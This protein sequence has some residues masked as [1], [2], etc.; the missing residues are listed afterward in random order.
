MKTR[1]DTHNGLAVPICAALAVLVT[2]ASVRAGKLGSFER[3][4]GGR[5]PPPRS[6][7]SSDDSSSSLGSFEDDSPPPRRRPRRRPPPP[8]YFHHEDPYYY[9]GCWYCRYHHPCLFH[10]HRHP[11]YDTDL[12]AVPPVGTRTNEVEEFVYE[13]IAGDPI[14]PTARFDFGWQAVE[15]DVQAFDSALEIGYGPIA[16]RGRI[17]HYREDDPDD[18]LDLSSILG[19]WRIPVSQEMELDVGIGGA[20]LEGD[21]R[22]SG[23]NISLALRAWVPN[24]YIG[25]EYRGEFIDIGDGLNSNDF[26]VL[27]HVKWVA[28]RAG[29]RW[30]HTTHDSLDGPF[31][32][33]SLTF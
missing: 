1:H 22:Q 5:P 16:A 4:T 20:V 32:G 18:T 19:L 7:S 14:L 24:R 33:A 6:S 9:H 23:V 28:L 8:G 25:F 27:L 12:S 29:Y 21:E 15:S 26:S 31:A 3:S 10:Y 11:Y 17:T 30:V 2:A 13:S